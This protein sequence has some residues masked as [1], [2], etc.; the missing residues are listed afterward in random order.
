[1]NLLTRENQ[2]GVNFTNILRTA[3]MP[4]AP[5]SVKKIQLSPWYLF[6]L[7]GSTSVKA[8]HKTLMKLSLDVESMKSL[9]IKIIKQICYLF[10]LDV[11]PI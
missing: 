4:V 6:T 8:V 3:F 2:P 10:V 11:F 1:M 7:L 9:K 5:Q